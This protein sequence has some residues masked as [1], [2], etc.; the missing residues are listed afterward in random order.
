MVAWHAQ[1]YFGTKVNAGQKEEAVVVGAM[2][3]V[4]CF[5]RQLADRAK[6]ER[7]AMNG[8]ISIF[9]HF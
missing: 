6:A 7:E 4:R 9:E 2:I 1:E 5:D 3:V 8:K